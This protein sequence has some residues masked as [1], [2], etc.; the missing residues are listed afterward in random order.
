MPQMR[1][2]ETRG[3][4]KPHNMQTSRLSGFTLSRPSV[5]EAE[6]KVTTMPHFQYRLARL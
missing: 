6:L 3:P 4:M 5:L 1:G 2:Q